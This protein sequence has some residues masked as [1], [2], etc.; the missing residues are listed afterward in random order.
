MKRVHD[1]K[2]DATSSTGSPDI[3][4]GEFEPPR[5]STG[6][7][8]KA[9][10]TPEEAPAQRQRITAIP[11]HV[12]T[13]SAFPPA[14]P[15]APQHHQVPVP[16]QQQ[17]ARRN[18]HRQRVISQWTNQRELLAR[19]MHFI[20]SPDDENSLQRL[21]QNIEELRRLSEAARELP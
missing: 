19:Q 9:G 3:P 10:S 6:R 15:A 2:E 7:K 5:R 12:L 1:H 20:Q 14:P 21:S 11:S 4:S 18:Q 17:Q 13:N 8:R 16:F